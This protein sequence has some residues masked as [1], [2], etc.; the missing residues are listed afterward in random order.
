MF[1][2]S[3]VHVSPL[4]YF[5]PVVVYEHPGQR[6]KLEETAANHHGDDRDEELKKSGSAVMV[7]V[8]GKFEEKCGGKYLS[9]YTGTPQHSSWN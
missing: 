3:P 2:G 1:R 9:L 8:T 4:E 5:R 6:Q 7:T